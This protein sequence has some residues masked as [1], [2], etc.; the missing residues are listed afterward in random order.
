MT[1]FESHPLDV[2]LHKNIYTWMQRMDFNSVFC[3]N[4]KEDWILHVR[5]KKAVLYWGYGD[6]KIKLENVDS[7]RK[8]EKWRRYLP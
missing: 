6:V 4:E 1:H 8:E 3:K 7:H 5:K 2:Y